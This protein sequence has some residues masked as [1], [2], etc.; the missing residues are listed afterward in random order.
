MSA[1]TSFVASGVSRIILP[2]SVAYSVSW[3]IPIGK[4]KLEPTDVGCYGYRRGIECQFDHSKDG[5][6]C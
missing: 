3:I 4:E 6:K 2:V 1:A 5:G